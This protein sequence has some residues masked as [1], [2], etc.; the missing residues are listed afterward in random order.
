MLIYP[1][2]ISDQPD[3][4]TLIPSLPGQHRFGL[5]RLISFLEPLVAKGLRSVIL[6]GVPIES[7]VKYDTVSLL[8][9]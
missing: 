2:F 4:M 6:F 7:G 8:A 3:E 1:L 9:P 5:N